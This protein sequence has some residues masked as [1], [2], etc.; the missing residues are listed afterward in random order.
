[1]PYANQL[2]NKY[3]KRQEKVDIHDKRIGEFTEQDIDKI[4]QVSDNLDIQPVDLVLPPTVTTETAVLSTSATSVQV[5]YSG[6]YLSTTIVDSY[7][8]EEVLCDVI[9]N[10]GS[11]TI[12]VAEP[13]E[14]PLNISVVHVINS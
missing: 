14:N 7:T 13:P 5:P 10:N 9:H 8:N 11:V 4:L 3:N 12:S 1:M 2:G 6:V